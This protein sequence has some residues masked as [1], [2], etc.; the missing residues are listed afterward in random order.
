M[1]N[2]R[3]H[4]DT[5]LEYQVQIKFKT[6]T[7]RHRTK[8]PKVKLRGQTIGYRSTNTV[9]MTFD[10]RD[11]DFS[12]V[13]DNDRRRVM[14][15]FGTRLKSIYSN[16]SQSDRVKC[17]VRLRCLLYYRDEII[18]VSLPIRKRIVPLEREIPLI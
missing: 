16:H 10:Y 14:V 15:S 4:C 1:L 7:R 18:R 5:R 2:D 11:K 9:A 3:C 6:L 13:R 8:S 17:T 12:A